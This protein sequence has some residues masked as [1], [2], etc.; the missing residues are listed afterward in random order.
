[1]SLIIPF[2]I[3][4]GLALAAMVF[5]ILQI[6]KDMGECPQSGASARAAS[7]VIAVGYA[8]CG[9]GGLIFASSIMVSKSIPLEG[10]LLSL[11]L[12][13][14]ALGIGFGIAM[15]NLREVAN[16]AAIAAKVMA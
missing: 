9:L 13:I 5:I 15:S 6:G 4:G 16:K 1:M 8:A 7:R 11:G 3:A 12:V 10:F 14:F 2:F